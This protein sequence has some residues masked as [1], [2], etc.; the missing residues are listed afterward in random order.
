MMFENP[1]KSTSPLPEYPNDIITIITKV[2]KSQQCLNQETTT[3]SVNYNSPW[4]KIG[5]DVPPSY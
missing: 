1:M 4:N 5:V 2:Y 3:N